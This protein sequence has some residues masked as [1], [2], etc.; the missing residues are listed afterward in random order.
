MINSIERLE[1]KYANYAYPG[2]RI[3]ADGKKLLQSVSQ[4]QTPPEFYQAVSKRRDDFLDFS[5]DYEPVRA[6]FSG[7]QLEIFTRALDMLAIYE[8]SKAYIVDPTLEDIVTQMH[9]IVRMEKPY[10]NIPKL[11][12]LRDKFMAAYVK[13][14]KVEQ[15]PV[16]DSIDQAMRRVLD[17]LSGK[18]YEESKHDN[19]YRQFREIRDGAEHCN[20]VSTLR[21]YADKADALKRRFLDEM[22]ALDAQIAQKKAEEAAKRAVEDAGKSGTG[23]PSTEPV[24]TSIVRK[25]KRIPIKQMTG[26]ASWRLES[27]EDVDRHLTELRKKLTAQ[28]DADTI[29]NI[30]F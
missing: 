16:L 4:I 5:E 7:E 8:D 14:L 19:Y 6:F 2:K 24:T 12:D 22:D 11:P 9:T 27:M 17:N 20:N 15:A 25:T 23:T 29:I 28:L 30:E 3:L 10:G 18:E 26:T 21:S 13:V 1:D